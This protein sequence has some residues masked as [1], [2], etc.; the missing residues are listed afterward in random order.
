MSIP[1]VYVYVLSP[2][3]DLKVGELKVFT[4]PNV[5]KKHLRDSYTVEGTLC[6][7]PRGQLLLSR[8]KVN[9]RI[10]GRTIIDYL[11]IEEFLS[12]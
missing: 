11:D 5:I 10:D 3:G 2:V 9:P 7:P 12:K 6:L 8:H 1:V 4:W